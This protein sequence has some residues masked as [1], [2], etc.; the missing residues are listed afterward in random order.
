MQSHETLHN[1]YRTN[2][3]LK[4]HHGFSID[5]LESMLPY[6]RDIYVILIKQW[7]EEESNNK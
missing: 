1:F 4:K 7:L 5:E 6:E 2:F 3:Q